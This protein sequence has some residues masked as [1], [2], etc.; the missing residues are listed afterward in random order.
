MS[1]FSVSAVM[2]VVLG[3]LVVPLVFIPYV[4]W[5]YRK[6]AIGP[7]HALLS[8]AAVVYG[9][10][11]WTYTILPLPRPEELS[12]DGSIRAQLIPFQFLADIH[13]AAGLGAVTD[14]ALWQV[15]LNV[16]LF[17]PFGVFVR[18]LLGWSPGRVIVAGAAVSVLIELTQLTGNWWTYPCAYRLFDTDDL[19][20]NT[21]GAALGLALV[22][23]ARRLPG[24]HA[25]PAGRPAPVRPPRR[26]L[27]MTVDLV[28]VTLTTIAL[29]IIGR[30]VATAFGGELPQWQA[31][32]DIAASVA[33]IVLLT[34]ALPAYLGGATL[35]QRLV[36]L[37][38]VRPDG[39]PP[40]LWQWAVR[41]FA[42]IGVYLLLTETGA[43]LAIPA[44]GH[45]AQLWV[46]LS[47][48][49]V[50][51]VHTRGIS[52]YA[53]GLVA[54]DARDPDVV[55]SARL[56]GVDPRHL[57]SA[58]IALGGGIYLAGTLLVA[59]SA[60]APR[61][62]TG[63]AAIAA[64]GLILASF[65]LVGYLLYNGVV[66]I[67]REGRSLGNLL[68]LL[69]TVGVLTLVIGLTVAALLKWTWLG[70]VS[71]VGLAVSAYLGFV[72]GAFLL[73]GQ[74]YARRDPRPGMDAIVVLGSRVFGDRVPPLLAARIDRALAIQAAEIAA[75]RAPLLVLSGGQGPDETM[76]EG[77]AMARYAVAHGAD[78]ALVRRE[79]ASK[80]TEEN[81]LL[82]RELLAA[83]AVGADLVV[84]TNDFHAFRAAIIAREL[85]LRAQVVGAPT[86]RYFFPSAVL[87]EFVGVLAR[88]PRWHGFALVTVAA[89]SGALAWLI[90]R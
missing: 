31:R 66:V 13:W 11:L 2:A 6:G 65:V 12:C 78:A 27:G 42:G 77:E 29:T 76:P 1:G 67:R 58:V 28:A 83:E 52:G 90:A 22:P 44:L 24:Q 71:I 4:A 60:V 59:L 73:Y 56:G 57:S 39:Q 53:A 5:S 14:P 82:T 84:V 51:L 20:A 70:V 88:S 37:R 64:L 63:V 21:A 89:L 41:G 32:I 79:L 43:N 46:G 10:A 9:M 17:V 47:A 81:L 68:A 48:L 18:H 72:F 38:F 16:L 61:V 69:A 25:R 85:G 19:L 3:L 36:F 62:G 40:R 55:A 54:V 50:L 74:F 33:A 86:A 26:L 45:L 7:G 8:A 23:L 49:T 15:V 30:V 34:V 87:R 35:G 80:T 75:G